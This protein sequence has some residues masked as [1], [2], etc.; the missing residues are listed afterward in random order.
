ML[1]TWK[2]S[3]VPT[4][5]T[6]NGVVT[7]PIPPETIDELIKDLTKMIP[8]ITEGYQN[9][10][11]NEALLSRKM[12]FKGYS[13]EELKYVNEIIKNMDKAIEKF[14]IQNQK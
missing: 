9:E 2:H 6:S 12:L 5:T 4:S 7:M 8:N 14:T 3:I 10:R 11:M 1:E 13:N